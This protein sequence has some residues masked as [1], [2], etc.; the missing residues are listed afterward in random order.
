[1][2]TLYIAV[3]EHAEMTALG[4][5]LE[6]STV[7]IS[8]T[9]AQS[10]VIPGTG[11]KR[12]K[13]R[14]F[15]DSDCFVTWGENPVAVTDGSDGRPMGAENPEYFDIEAGHKIAVIQRA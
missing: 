10:A 3:F 8:G 12:K 2:A 11:R 1:M 9:S 15:A 5:P 4:E 14:L 13:V 6:E 7:T